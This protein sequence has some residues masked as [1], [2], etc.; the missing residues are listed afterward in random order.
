M[1]TT[2][3]SACNLCQCLNKGDTVTLVL[4]SGYTIFGTV[5]NI[6]CDCNVLRLGELVGFISPTGNVIFIIS[7]ATLFVC[8]QDIS[9]LVKEFLFGFGVELESS[10]LDS[11]KKIII[12]RPGLRDSAHSD[13]LKDLSDCNLCSCLS[14]DDPIAALGTSG[15]T[16]FLGLS[17]AETVVLDI[18]CDCSLLKLA[19]GFIIVPPASIDETTT[20][21]SLL[22]CEDIQFLLL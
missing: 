6:L 16:T 8:C 9:F 11:G 18:L 20:Q 22:C 2:Q 15:G 4:N 1:E 19:P 10:E 17:P 7:S 13:N 12:K 5:T 21:P 14:K 3:I